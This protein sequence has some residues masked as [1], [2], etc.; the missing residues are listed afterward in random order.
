M[1]EFTQKEGTF[2][3]DRLRSFID[4][5]RALPPVVRLILGFTYRNL[6]ANLRY[7]SEYGKNIELLKHTET[8]SYNKLQ[9]LQLTL[10]QELYIHAYIN[11]PYYHRLF[12]QIG[13]KIGDVTDL[14]DLRRIPCL[15]K[16]LIRHHGSELLARNISRSKRLYMNTGG[17]TGIPLEL[18][19][20]KG[21]SRA[22][23]WAFMHTLWRRVG[24]RYGD[25]SVMLRG[26]NV[27]HGLWQYEP[28][29]NRLI[30]SAYHLNEPNLPL[31][32][33]KIRNFAPKFI[34]AYPSNL[35]VLARYME[36]HKLPP[37]RSVKAILAGSENLFP[38]QRGLFETVFDCRVYS[39][40]GHGEIVALG[41]ECEEST[42][43]H[44]FPEY[45]ILELLTERGDTVTGVGEMG[46]IVATGFNNYVMPLIRYRTGDMGIWADGSCKCGRNYP[47][48]ARIEG[49]KQ[50]LV[51]TSDGNIITLTGLIFAQHFRAFS[52]IKQM[53]LVQKSVGELTLRI[54]PDSDYSRSDD[55]DE[56]RGKI[57]LAVGDRLKLRFDYVD[58]IPCTP[59][60]KRLFL[61]QDLRIDEYLG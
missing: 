11:V 19:Y 17:S 14:S 59:S 54:V 28:I 20:E 51:I 21:I 6:P 42:D 33:Q 34:E 41:G 25:S 5:Y 27:P 22:R 26:W 56:V 23:E 40:Y 45:G 37:F 7:G 15:T 35:T 43:L 1:P 3:E 48:M 36:K 4:R 9:E 30:M 2:I 39:W 57:F 61:I 46:E 31:Y 16:D 29:R 24:W 53:Q 47:R 10:I 52:H 38:I 44:M 13:L 32:I 60:G 49:R 55:E 58:E 12:D 8:W 18:F 50:E